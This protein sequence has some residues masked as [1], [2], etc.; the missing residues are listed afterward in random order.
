MEKHSS[1]N[2][3]CEKL[4][5]EYKRTGNM[6]LKQKLVMKYLYLVRNIAVQMKNVYIGFAQ[7]DDIINEGVLALMNGID[8]YDP[9]SGVWFE[10]YISRRLRGMVLDLAR[11]Q[12]WIPRGVRKNIRE[13]ET[14]AAE[15]QEKLGRVPEEKEVA[16]ALE[17]PV[18]KYRD[19]MRKNMQS[20][21][22]SLNLMLEEREEDKRRQ[23]R[24]ISQD[25]AAQPENAYLKKELLQTLVQAVHTLKE[26]EQMVLSLYYVEERS[27]REISEIL[28]VS[29]PRISQIHGRA[30]EKLRVCLGVKKGG[31]GR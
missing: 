11:K 21:V 9:Q 31:K 20:H 18:D 15:L 22:I 24:I 2:I 19:M 10:S 25:E 13:A 6:E 7:T 4:M 29:E 8:R 23:D 28:E 3:D 5:L 26:K 17:I 27:M 1:E 16:D 30:I 14:V 12:D